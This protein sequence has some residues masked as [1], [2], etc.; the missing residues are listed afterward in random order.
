M[1]EDQK[2]SCSEES[3]YEKRTEVAG[4]PETEEDRKEIISL[5]LRRFE[6]PEKHDNFIY[7]LP[8]F[9]VAKADGKVSFK[10][11]YR[12]IRDA[13]ELGLVALRDKVEKHDFMQ[14]SRDN[15]LK[16]A[17]KT[18]FDDLVLL[19]DAINAMLDAYPKTES[20]RIRRHIHQMCLDVAEAKGPFLGEKITPGE[21][22][23]LDRIFKEI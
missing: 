6:I 21:Q 10:E 15:Y 23:M 8:A 5:A 11:V 12:A 14:F 3:G 22:E 19:T 7:V 1:N 4:G 13:Y 18:R 2:E 16:F 17:G 9:Y 20:D